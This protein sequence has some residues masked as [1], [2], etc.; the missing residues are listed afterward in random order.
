MPALAEALTRRRLQDALDD[1]EGTP[2]KRARLHEGSERGPA[3]ALAQLQ[4][5]RDYARELAAGGAVERGTWLAGWLASDWRRTLTAP[6]PGDVDVT[7][8]AAGRHWLALQPH[9]GPLPALADAALDA[10]VLSCVETLQFLPRELEAGVYRALQ[11]WDGAS[12]A[13]LQLLSRLRPCVFDQLD[14]LALKPLSARC[15]AQ[16]LPSSL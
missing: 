2:V 1:P 11:T 6:R 4:G 7:R 16:L 10:G 12:L 5:P 14:R 13:P 15:V 9:G 3:V 8:S